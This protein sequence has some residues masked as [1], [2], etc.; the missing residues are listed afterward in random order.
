METE[1]QLH[2]VYQNNRRRLEEEEDQ[3]VSFQHKGNQAIEE[4]HEDIEAELRH[5]DLDTQTT[6]FIRQKILKAQENYEEIVSRSKAELQIKQK[7]NELE[8]RQKLDKLD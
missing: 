5:I 3:I 1:A 7:E 2:S 8:Y 6:S 4:A